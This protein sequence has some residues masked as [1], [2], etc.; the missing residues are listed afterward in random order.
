MPIT[1]TFKVFGITVTVKLFQTEQQKKE[2]KKQNRH[3]DQ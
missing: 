1:I 2:S 3:S